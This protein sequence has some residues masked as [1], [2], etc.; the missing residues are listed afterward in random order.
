MKLP[1]RR[2]SRLGFERLEDR[3]NPTS[4]TV[5]T[6]LDVVNPSDGVISLR[7]AIAAAE[8]DPEAD[9]SRS[10]PPDASRTMSVGAATA[11]EPAGAAGGAGIFG[12]DG[13][14]GGGGGGGTGNGEGVVYAGVPLSKANTFFEDEP[15]LFVGI[16]FTI[17]DAN[18]DG[19]DDLIVVAA[20]GGGP[21]RIV[22][23]PLTGEQVDNSF[24]DDEDIRTEGYGVGA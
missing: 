9:T 15:S 1:P 16:R 22:V 5:T 8:S 3:T 24:F 17:A 21:R 18:G 20:R 7:E 19:L 11:A 12:G 23:N 6:F 13:G 2:R 4:S 10:Y 14:F